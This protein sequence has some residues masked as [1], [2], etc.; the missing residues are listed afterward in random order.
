MGRGRSEL[1]TPGFSG[2]FGVTVTKPLKSFSSY[3]RRGPGRPGWFPTQAP[4]RSGRARQ[5]IRFLISGL[6]CAAQQAVDHTGRGKTVMLLQ[7]HELRPRQRFV[8]ATPRQ[9]SF[10]DPAGGP[11]KLLE[12]GIVTDD[13]IV[14]VMAFQLLRELLVLIPNRQVQGFSRHHAASASS[15]RLSRP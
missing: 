13:P 4:H 12:A 11:Q 1:P 9:P 5:C 8:P 2:G 7:P 3:W 10:P 14:T 6:R 15:A